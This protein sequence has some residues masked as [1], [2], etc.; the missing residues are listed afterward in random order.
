MWSATLAFNGMTT[1]GMGLVSFPAHMV[2]HSLSALYDIAHGEGL[3]ITLPGWMT[4]AMPK[5]PSKF[6][7]LGRE[8][9]H[10][11][12]KDDLKAAE[13]GINHLKRWF[14]SIGS[15]VALKEVNVSE[16][17]IGRI[18]ENASATALVWGMKAYTKEVISDILHL[19]K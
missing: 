8:I 2:G 14:S 1:A 12:E 13:E 9:F 5:N 10:I 7:R 18:A 17:E 4:Y 11:N 3:S 19:C 6:A 15:P 16:A